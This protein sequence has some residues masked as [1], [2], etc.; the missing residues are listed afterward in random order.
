MIDFPR[1]SIA[2]AT[3]ACTAVTATAYLS[4]QTDA[5]R[6]GNDAALTNSRCRADVLNPSATAPVSDAAKLPA[7]DVMMRST[8]GWFPTTSSTAE[9]VVAALPADEATNQCVRRQQQLDWNY[10][11]DD[12]VCRLLTPRRRTSISGLFRPDEDEGKEKVEWERDVDEPGIEPAFGG[13]SLRESAAAALFNNSTVRWRCCCCSESQPGSACRNC[14]FVQY[15]HPPHPPTL[16]HRCCCYWRSF[17][18]VRS[19]RALSTATSCR[20]TDEPSPPR[21]PCLDFDKMQRTTL[22]NVL[23]KTKLKLAKKSSVR[24]AVRP[25]RL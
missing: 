21:R 7:A 5:V 15:R 4:T 6:A 12:E 24:R 3:S 2:T 17:V 25:C 1:V 20:R 14:V 23:E 8:F 9:G 16:T 13:L 18:D 11:A 19:R 22:H 10:A